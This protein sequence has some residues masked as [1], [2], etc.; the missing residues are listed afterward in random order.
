MF[1]DLSA[2]S[3]IDRRGRWKSPVFSVCRRPPG[4]D[5]S[6]NASA[7]SSSVRELNRIPGWLTRGVQRRP[8]RPEDT[9]KSGA[10]VTISPCTIRGFQPSRLSGNALLSAGSCLRL[11]PQGWNP[12]TSHPRRTKRSSLRQLAVSPNSRAEPIFKSRTFNQREANYDFTS[13]ILCDRAADRYHYP[14]RGSYA[15]RPRG[16]GGRDRRWD[17]DLPL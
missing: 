14:H 13:C 7:G 10:I 9:V 4:S 6:A 5:T 12:D 1:T 16:P 8:N 15:S 3:C 17:G 11:A 2:R